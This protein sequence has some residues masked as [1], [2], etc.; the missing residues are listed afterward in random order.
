MRHRLVV[1]GLVLILAP[2]CG[3]DEPVDPGEPSPAPVVTVTLNVEG[4]TVL[5]GAAVQIEA[6]P[7]DADGNELED[8]AVEWSTSDTELCEFLLKSTA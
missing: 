6:S 2:G 5:V 3:D 7:R 4:D 1:L 8:R